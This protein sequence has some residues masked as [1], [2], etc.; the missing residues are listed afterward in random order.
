MVRPQVA[1]EGKEIK[2]ILPMILCGCET[3][4]LKLREK[5]RLRAFKNRMPRRIF[6]P[7]RAKMTRGWR[8]LHDKELHNL[9]SLPSVIRMQGG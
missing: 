5:H 9:Y 7:K 6:R 8:K 4:S 3:W 1:D 2:L